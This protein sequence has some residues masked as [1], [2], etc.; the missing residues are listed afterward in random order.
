MPKHEGDDAHVLRRTLHPGQKYGYDEQKQELSKKDETIGQQMQ[1]LSK[2]D[3]TIGQQMQELS[4]QKQEL[5]KKDETIGQQKQEI[6]RLRR[7][8]EK[9]RQKKQKPVSS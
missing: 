7:E 9:A 2:K 1:E 6:E 3:K 8:L 5:S 4:H